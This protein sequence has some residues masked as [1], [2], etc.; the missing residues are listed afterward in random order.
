MKSVSELVSDKRWIPSGL[1][2]GE[3]IRTERNMAAYETIFELD[4]PCIVYSLSFSLY[5]PFSG[6]Q[7]LRVTIDGVVSEYQTKQKIISS[8]RHEG[9]IFE[10]QVCEKN[11]KVEAYASNDPL[12][13]SLSYFFAERAK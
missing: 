4:T 1:G 3:F 12:N 13:I 11:F 2:Q 6:S 5:Q 7:H 9:A 10:P 8:Q